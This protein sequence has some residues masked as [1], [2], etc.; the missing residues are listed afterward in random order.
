MGGLEE[1][2][3]KKIHW[4]SLAYVE[5]WPLE[6][7]RVRTEMVNEGKMKWLIIHT[8]TYIYMANKYEKVEW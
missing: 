4:Q 1:I 6:S 5:K 2:I 8:H 7:P 3:A